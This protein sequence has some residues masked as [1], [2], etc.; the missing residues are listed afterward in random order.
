LNGTGQI[1][2]DPAQVGGWPVI[3]AGAPT[4]DSDQDGMPDDWEKQYGFS[5]H[6]A[7]DGNLDADNDGYRNVE[8]YLN[9]SNPLEQ[10]QNTLQECSYLPVVTR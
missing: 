2:D 1:I 5:P 9:S 4:A 8:E 10:D 6:L 7:T 3:A